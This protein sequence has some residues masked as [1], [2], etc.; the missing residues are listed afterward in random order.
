[1]DEVER[2]R[3]QPA[4]E[5]VV[6]HEYDVAECLRVHELSR[7]VKHCVVD[8]GP[9][10]LLRRGRPTRSAAEEPADRAAADVE[11]ACSTA[12]ADLVEKA[13]AA[14]LPHSR[15]E[16][17]P[18]QFGGLARQQIL[19]ETTSAAPF[20]VASGD[21]TH[22][23]NLAGSS[24]S[25]AGPRRAKMRK[26]ATRIWTVPCAHTSG[27]GPRRRASSRSS[28]FAGRSEILSAAGRVPQEPPTG[29]GSQKVRD[30]IPL[31]SIGSGRTVMR[32]RGRTAS[33]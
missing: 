22:Y 13:A 5:Q 20:E 21:G 15:L 8:V 32:N 33:G 23:A 10:H 28:A 3:L 7:G 4:R 26:G 14:R 16:L 31:G 2:G 12:F 24:A 19:L 18:L 27:S 1:M 11:D 29:A 30:S 6:L 17:K 9:H 25:P